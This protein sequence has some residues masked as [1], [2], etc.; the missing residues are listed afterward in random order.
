MA[1]TDYPSLLFTATIADGQTTSGTIN[2]GDHTLVGVFIPTGF[3]GTTLTFEASPDGGV[4]FLTILNED[5]T[6]FT[7]TCTASRYVMVDPSR[8]CGAGVLRLV[9]SVQTGPVTLTLATRPLS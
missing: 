7:L 3:E 8:L 6:T 1:A 2:L 9:A 4:T 5:G